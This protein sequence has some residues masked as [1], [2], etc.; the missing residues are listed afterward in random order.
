MMQAVGKY[1]FGTARQ[2]NGLSATM[3]LD[4]DKTQSAP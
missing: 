1:K 3:S 4:Y 2:A